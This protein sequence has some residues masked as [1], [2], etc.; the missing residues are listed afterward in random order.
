MINDQYDSRTTF[1]YETYY[2]RISITYGSLLYYDKGM[3]VIP[4][5]TTFYVSRCHFVM[6]ETHKISSTNKHH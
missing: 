3:Y 1:L 2:S 4:M 5:H 6:R